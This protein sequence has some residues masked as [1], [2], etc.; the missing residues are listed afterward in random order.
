MKEQILAFLGFHAEV[1][2]RELAEMLNVSILDKELFNALFN[3]M[4]EKRIER[5]HNIE[6]DRYV[7]AQED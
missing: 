6:G 1:S 4:A 5:R 2:K 7:L 3:L